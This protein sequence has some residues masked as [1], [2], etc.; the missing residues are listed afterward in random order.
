LEV[1]LQAFAVARGR[2]PDAV[3]HVVTGSSVAPAPGVVFHRE[4]DARAM[5]RLFYASNIFV[6]PSFKEPLGLVFLEAMWSKCAC[7]GTRTGSMPEFI[8]EGVTGYLVEP[9]DVAALSQRLMDLLGDAAGTRVMG[10]KGYLQA[11][12]YWNWDA[13]VG[14]MLRVGA[15]AHDGGALINSGDGRHPS[16][17]V[18]CEWEH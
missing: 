15:W 1:L 5:K 18:P 14:R 3:L 11:R 17:L 4:L 9:G 8:D 7:I 10:E 13:T 12:S 6:M 16:P 2:Y